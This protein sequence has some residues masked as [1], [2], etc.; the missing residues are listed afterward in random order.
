MQRKNYRLFQ[1]AT[2]L[3]I[4]ASLLVCISCNISE[5]NR[6][7]FATSVNGESSLGEQ[8]LGVATS[9]QYDFAGEETLRS[10]T[11]SYSNFTHSLFRNHGSRF[12]SYWTLVCFLISAIFILTNILR[13]YGYQLMPK[14]N[15]SCIRIAKFIEQSDGKK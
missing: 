10:A 12:H 14:P 7:Y 8:Y 6:F 2:I 9:F 15:F 11:S 1:S 13:S 3:F 4:I 5:S